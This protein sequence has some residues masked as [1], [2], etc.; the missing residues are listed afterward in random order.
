VLESKC[1]FCGAAF[2]LATEVG[3]SPTSV[4][5]EHL[6]ANRIEVIKCIRS[7]SGLGLAEVHRALE[8]LPATFSV[9]DS[10]IA[11]SVA[12]QELSALGCAGYLVSE[13]ARLPSD[14]VFVGHEGT[15]GL[16][17]ESEGNAKIEAIK[18]VREV[19]DLGLA[20]AK[21][22]VETPRML[23]PITS[24]AS[25]EEI[26]RRF[27]ALGYVVSFSPSGG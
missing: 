19:C 18:L 26:R 8:R 3:S 20:E 13:P 25:H 9:S 22:A 15:W 17:I 2:L 11:P 21:T 10:K 5:I 14:P 23:V 4:T 6:G 16:R 1:R 27:A 7:F 12:L 24:R